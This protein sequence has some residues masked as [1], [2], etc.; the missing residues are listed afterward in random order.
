MTGIEMPM[1]LKD[2]PR[3][4]R[5]NDVSISVYW[6][7]PT[8]K[9]KDGEEEPG[10]A[11]PLHNAQE[12]KPNHVNLLMIGD[13]VKHYCWV[14]HFS[15]LISAQYTGAHG[16]H[17]YCHYCL[18]GFYGIAIE[19]QC[20]RLEDA[21]R[22]RDDHEKECFRH[23][24]QK[25]SFPKDPCVKFEALEKQVRDLPFLFLISSNQIKLFWVRSRLTRN[26]PNKNV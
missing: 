2:I 16:E 13:D 25:T 26:I 24:G 21:K 5:Q 18:H 23:G 7:K 10:F 3:F 12:V 9:N 6:W 11:Y 17:A 22:R 19:G 8:Q 14:K 20:T 15:R 4:E 1:Q